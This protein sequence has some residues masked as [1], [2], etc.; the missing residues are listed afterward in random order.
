MRNEIKRN[1]TDKDKLINEII[2]IEWKMFDH[3]NNQGGRAGCQDDEWTFYVM[4]FSQFSAFN[5]EML[6]SY[7]E[8][9]KVALSE[10]RNLLMEKYAYMM[11][12]TDPV[13]FDKVLKNNIPAVS[14]AKG[15]LVDRIANMLIRYEQ[16]FSAK[17]PV[18]AGRGR[19]LFGNDQN[20]VS[21]HIYAIGE[22]K[23]YSERTLRLYYD[24]LHAAELCGD[25]KNPSIIIHEAT[26]S[27]Y[28]YKSLE[29]A[30]NKMGKILY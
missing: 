5:P 22:L 28:G 13:Y 25:M 7:K 12:F 4:R 26:I 14:P 17:Y 10:G 6:H 27:F 23:T 2:E 21:F 29:D 16:E 11:E 1:N 3:V 18:L 30:E 19:P 20:D 15:D 8:D 24:Y 9:L